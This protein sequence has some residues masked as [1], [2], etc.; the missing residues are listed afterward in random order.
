MIAHIGKQLYDHVAKSNVAHYDQ[1]GFKQWKR[2]VENKMEA[3]GVKDCQKY[4][5]SLHDKGMT[6]V[7]KSHLPQGHA[8]I[9]H[10]GK[11]SVTLSIASYL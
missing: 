4:L 11:V 7:A 9:K 8:H 3:E 5:H 6:A 2:S 10:T 1:H